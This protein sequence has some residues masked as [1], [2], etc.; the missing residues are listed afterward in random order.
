[1]LWFVFA[2]ISA[3]ATS[4]GSVIEKKTLMKEH[5]MEFSAVLALFT[6]I[7]SLPFFLFVDYSRIA[8]VPILIIFFASMLGAVAFLLIAKS[9]RHMELSAAS[10]LLALGT[11]FTVVMA[12]IFLQENLDASHLF[13][14]ALLIFGSYILETKPHHNLLEPLRVFR[15]SKY[16]RYML[17]ALLLYGTTSVFDRILLY[18]YDMQVEAFIAFGHV[19]GALSFFAMLAIFH[20]GFKG[21]KHGMKKAGLWIFFMAIFVIL[22]RFALAEAVKLT[23]VGLVS[24]IKRTSV[25]FSTLIGGELLHE[26][27]LFRKSV[28][29][30]IMV[31]GAFLIV[32]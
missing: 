27:N 25:F 5:A 13:G 2:L 8:L 9:V 21:I 17:F 14:I 24:A 11:G 7:L 23:F 4:I 19:F 22:S 6:L 1:M 31:I 29:A 26:K 30:V 12:F 18:R 28:A 20:D 32:L 15:K 10:P 16:I 3:V